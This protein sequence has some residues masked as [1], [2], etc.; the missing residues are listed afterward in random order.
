M[1][2]P[3]GNK[4]GKQFNS[5]TGKL[6]GEKSKRGKDLKT[7]L[8]GVLNET[9]PEKDLQK[10]KRKYG[11][12]ETISNGEAIIREVIRKAK[13]TGDIKSLVEIL[14]ITGEYSE[15]VEHEFPGSNVQIIVGKP[16]L[17]DGESLDT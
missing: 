5:E 1:P 17:K 11:I 12:D 7:Y 16:R 2:A 10:L 9:I 4:H 13:M 3:K 8:K 6:A 15:K 14:K